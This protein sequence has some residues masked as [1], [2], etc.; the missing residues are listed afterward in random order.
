MRGWVSPNNTL[1]GVVIPL[2]AADAV[3][4]TAWE[5]RKNGETMA[6]CIGVVP[7][8][9][10]AGGVSGVCS[11]MRDNTPLPLGGLRPA[12]KV[13]DRRGNQNNNVQGFFF[14]VGVKN[15][16]ILG[17]ELVLKSARFDTPYVTDPSVTYLLLS[18]GWHWTLKR[19]KADALSGV[20]VPI[21]SELHLLFVGKGSGRS[22]LDLF[23]SGKRVGS[24]DLEERAELGVQVRRTV[25]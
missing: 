7:P 18:D 2:P 23:C 25:D 8:N 11:D 5:L 14:N 12:E 3:D 19:E 16:L 10:F 6:K 4:L 9:E 20:K 21:G 22:R 24:V 1:V 17:S 15:S 13:E